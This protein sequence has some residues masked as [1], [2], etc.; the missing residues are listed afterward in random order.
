MCEVCGT[1][2]V[3]MSFNCWMPSFGRMVTADICMDCFERA[4][5]D[6]ELAVDI[7]KKR[8]EKKKIPLP[9]NEE[10]LVTLFEKE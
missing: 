1:D 2:K 6:I 5:S 3:E 4:D 7:V 9:M 10:T 8:A